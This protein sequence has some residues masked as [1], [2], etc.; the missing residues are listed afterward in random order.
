MIRKAD[1]D[2]KTAWRSRFASLPP[3]ARIALRAALLDLRADALQRPWPSTGRSSTST[4]AT[5]PAPFPDPAHRPP[6]PGG[7]FPFRPRPAMEPRWTR[8]K[9][10]PNLTV[11][12]E[13]RRR[14]GPPTITA[15]PKKRLHDLVDRLSEDHLE[16]VERYLTSLCNEQDPA[17]AA[18]LSAPL[19][20]EEVTDED[21]E[22]I[23]QGRQDI[24]ASRFVSDEQI[25]RIL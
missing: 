7:T 6:Q 4:P 9:F 14:Q 16:P 5:S 19:D 3:P 8:P 15:L 22:D 21:R 20:D 11:V 2:L 18:A 23:E 17:M 12:H 1:R 25:R 24:A 10:V 13:N